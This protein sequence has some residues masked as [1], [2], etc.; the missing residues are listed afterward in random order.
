MENGRAQRS[1]HGACLL[2]RFFLSFPE[3]I[4]RN[5][6]TFLTQ[7]I[8]IMGWRDDSVVKN[9]PSL[10]KDAVSILAQALGGSQPPVTSPPGDPVSSFSFRE[11]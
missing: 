3:A 2:P 8:E 11:Q 5:H 1:S 10:S 7:S 6:N 4:Y 9:T